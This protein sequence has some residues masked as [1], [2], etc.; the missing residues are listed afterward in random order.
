MNQTLA[1][2]VFGAADPIGQQLRLGRVTSTSPMRTIVGVVG[3]VLHSELT[4]RPEPEIYVPFAQAPASTMF[5]AART[6]GDPDRFAD[7]VRGS[8][9]KVDSGQPVYHLKSMRSLVDAA[10]LP[11]TT[12][13]AIMTLFAMLA[14]VLASVGI[15][16]VTSYT[17]TQQ[18]RE[19]GVRLALGATPLD[20]L[21]I[22]IRRGLTL[23]AIGMVIGSVLAI[24][25]GQA[26]AALLPSV[27]AADALPYL[28]VAAIVFAV[29]AAACYVPARRAMRLNPVEI[30]RA[31]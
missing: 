24:G 28:A 9:A 31:D 20:V 25:A 30:L 11:N 29:G 6:A 8:L 13:T 3:D 14:L 26:L 22:V 16:G 5:L 27:R 18:T 17:V 21:G 10:M 7:A 19:F 23:I 12:A 15:Y 4:S 2:R 1:L